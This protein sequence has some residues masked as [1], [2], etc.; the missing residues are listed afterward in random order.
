V[1]GGKAQK[2]EG[3]ERYCSVKLMA[4][5]I[6][7]SQNN[8]KHKE[9]V[10]EEANEWIATHLDQLA[11]HAFKEYCEALIGCNLPSMACMHPTCLTLLLS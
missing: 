9:S 1:V 3:F 4:G 11:P 10:F 8:F 7:R 5:M 6:R 2:N